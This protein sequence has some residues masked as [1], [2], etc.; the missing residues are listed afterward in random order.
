[1]D[2]PPYGFTLIP[3]HYPLN[4]DIVLNYSVILRAYS[5]F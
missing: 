5:E 2:M 3:E 4:G 1:M